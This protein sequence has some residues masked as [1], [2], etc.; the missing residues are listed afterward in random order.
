[1]TIPADPV[2]FARFPEEKSSENAVAAEAE[3]PCVCGDV[4]NVAASTNTQTS[5]AFDLRV[6]MSLPLP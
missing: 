2:Q 3:G 5:R 4:M 1:M 6:F